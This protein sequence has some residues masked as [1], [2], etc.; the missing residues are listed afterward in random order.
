MESAGTGGMQGPSQHI[1]A[2]TLSSVS[3]LRLA[4]RHSVSPAATIHNLLGAAR[5]AARPPLP[6]RNRGTGCTPAAPEMNDVGKSC[7]HPSGVEIL[8]NME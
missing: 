4:P 2:G 1:G 5:P 6:S 7:P 3:L 8:I